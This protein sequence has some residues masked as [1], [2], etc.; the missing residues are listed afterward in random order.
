MLQAITDQFSPEILPL[1]VLG[2]GLLL[3]ASRYALIAGGAFWL[4]RVFKDKLAQRR[5][6][7]LPFTT[8]QVRREIGY[9]ALTIGLFAGLAAVAAAL[10]GQV[11][12]AGAPM[13]ATAVEWV[14]AIVA[15]PVALVL[16]DFY[17]YWAHRL[18]HVDWI[19][20]HVHRVHH[21]STNPS[22]FAALAFH[23][24]EAL[25][26]A[27]GVIVIIS[28]LQMPLPSLIVFGLLAFAINVVG[29]LGYELLP[30]AWLRS[31][32]GRWFNS[33]TGH[34]HHHRTFRY[35]FGLYTLIWDRLFG[36]LDPKFDARF[37]SQPEAQAV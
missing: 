10:T 28:F 23:P 27:A 19:Y 37:Q 13:P 7:K 20:P 4:S 24:I 2:G 26:E 6:Q 9:S 1:V 12:L 3:F 34:N 33:S 14:W 16:H 36:T 35:N 8:E 25:I 15:V 29:H 11:G 17:F 31:P 5:I 30:H 22:P 18:I 21:L 32:L